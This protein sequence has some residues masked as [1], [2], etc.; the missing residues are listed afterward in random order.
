MNKNNTCENSKRVYHDYKVGD[1][2]MLDNND[3]FRYDT[4]YKVPFEI[5]QCCVDGTVTLQ[6]GATKIRYIIR[7]IKQY[8][9]D[10]NIEDIKC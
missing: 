1:K 2:L 7:K 6:Y 9:S 3:N 8:T 4:P 5:T 10:T